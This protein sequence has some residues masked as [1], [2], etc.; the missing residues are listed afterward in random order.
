MMENKD[1]LL[2]LVT[3]YAAILTLV[4]IFCGQ[5]PYFTIKVKSQLQYNYRTSLEHNFPIHLENDFQF[6]DSNNETGYPYLIVPNSVHYV[7]FDVH[8]I[9]LS[10]YVSI[11][12]VLKNQK[13]DIIWIHCN[14]GQLYGQ[15]YKK[16]IERVKQTNTV[17]EI[18]R[19]GQ[20][21]NWF[22]WFYFR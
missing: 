13:P 2:D 14:C 18:R 10:H 17:F 9:E 22:K 8:Q 21:A 5:L 15:Y 6:K 11:L 7:L 1:I 16:V 20:T 4:F 12:S 19:I 3:I